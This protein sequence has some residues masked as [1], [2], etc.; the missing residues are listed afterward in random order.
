M[1]ETFGCPDEDWVTADGYDVGWNY[2]CYEYPSCSKL[3]ELCIYQDMTHV[4]HPNMASLTWEFLTS[5]APPTAA[6]TSAPTMCDDDEAWRYK[7]KS[8]KDCDW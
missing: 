7:G 6:P 2:T 4:I 1:T 3:G 8:S 5:G